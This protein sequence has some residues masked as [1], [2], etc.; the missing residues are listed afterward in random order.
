MQESTSPRAQFTEF[1]R[2]ALG[3]VVVSFVAAFL[4][5]YRVHRSYMAVGWFED[6]P[7]YKQAIQAWLTGHNPYN[8]SHAPLFF[9]Y[10]PSFLFMAGLLSHLVPPGWG[11][12]V[13]MA[14]IIVAVCG[15]PLVLARFYFQQWRL[16]VP[17][18]LLVFFASPRFTG[19]LALQTAN[20]ASIVYLLAFTSAIPGLRKN[21]WT[22]FYLVVLVAALTKITF[23]GLLL[24]P[25]LVG[26]QQW[27]KSM[28]CGAT[29]IA[30]NMA[31]RLFIPGLYG[32]FQWSLRQGIV[33]QQ[34]FGYGLF[35]IVARIG[36]RLG[37]GWAAYAVAI[38]FALTVAAM[39]FV[40]RSRLERQNRLGRRSSR[41]GLPTQVILAGN[42]IWMALV[43]M[44]L[45]LVN[46]R[47]M[48]YDVDVAL[49]AAF[50]VWA[51]VL[52]TQRLLLLTLALFLP[53]VAVPL[54]VHNRHLHG[55]YET[56][57][58]LVTFG[59]GYTRLWQEAGVFV[60]LAEPEEGLLT[61]GVP[62][63]S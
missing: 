63:E 35:G 17:F 46:P 16:G 18:L 20:V 50:W 29:V 58:V 44:A 48:Q 9:L 23:L 56:L 12:G 25:L 54:M 62:Q 55:I 11:N 22:W 2:P 30:V 61:V 10:P 1:K 21:N 27:T 19:V 32:G 37:A 41:G 38:G 33:L 57:L 49:F 36:H 53:C 42:P 14:A 43:V 7:V 39:L 8:A 26:I 40:L 6:L 13:F 59:L 60:A 47:E 52:R 24:L 5:Y 31:E 28:A 3:W 51:L 4:A 45:V 15:I 34:H